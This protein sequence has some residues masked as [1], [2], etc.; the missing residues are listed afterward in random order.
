MKQVNRKFLEEQVKNTLKEIGDSRAANLAGTEEFEKEYGPSF[1]KILLDIIVGLP[2][3]SAESYVDFAR[4]LEETG[5]Y[6]IGAQKY[7]KKIADTMVNLNNPDSRAPWN[8]LM[9]RFAQNA[10]MGADESG[11][12]LKSFNLMFKED[13]AKALVKVRDTGIKR[14]QSIP[15]DKKSV[16]M[17]ERVLVKTVED[18]EDVADEFDFNSG[19][20]DFVEFNAPWSKSQSIPMPKMFKD[21]DALEES[22]IYKDYAKDM[23]EAGNIKEE[24]EEFLMFHFIGLEQTNFQK[25]YNRLMLKSDLPD[26]ASAVAAY[27]EWNQQ[28]VKALAGFADITFS[29][30]TTAA[31]L[32]S[33]LTG[34]GAPAGAALA[35]GGTA[36]KKAV[37]SS[38]TKSLSSAPNKVA[39]MA[40]RTLESKKLGK[41]IDFLDGTLA[42]LS[43]LVTSTVIQKFENILD[44]W[45]GD[46]KELNNYFKSN[47]K[48]KKPEERIAFYEEKIY[49]AISS[50]AKAQAEI[51][52][53]VG[54][55]K[56][57]ISTRVVDPKYMKSLYA[58]FNI[59]KIEE[60]QERAE[61]ITLGLSNNLDQMSKMMNDIKKESG[62]LKQSVEGLLKADKVAEQEAAKKIKMPL[63]KA[64]LTNP[65]T[66][67]PKPDGKKS[68]SS[69][70]LFFVG[71]SIAQGMRDSSGGSDGETHTGETSQDILDKIRARFQTKQ[72]QEQQNNKTAIISVGT[73]DAM[74]AAAGESNFTPEK[75]SE[76]IKQIV[77]TLK[78]NGY[79]T[80]K[81]MPLMHHGVK[82]RTYTM[83]KGK[84]IPFNQEAHK[85]F[86]NSVNSQLSASKL[87][88]FDNSVELYND[89][90]HPKSPKQLL[91]KALSGSTVA[92]ALSVRSKP[93][94]PFDPKQVDA[95][96]KTSDK[97]KQQFEGDTQK[98]NAFFNKPVAEMSNVPR[99]QRE[100]AVRKYFEI[101][102]ASS[103]TGLPLEVLVKQMGAESGYINKDFLGDTK[104]KYGPSYGIGQILRTTGETLTKKSG[105][106][107]V[108]Y[109][110]I[111]SNNLDTATSE[112]ILNTKYLSRNPWWENATETQKQLLILYAYNMGAGNSKRGVKGFI[113]RAGGDIERGLSDMNA[114][115]VKKYNYKMGYGHK[116]MAAAG[117]SVPTVDFDNVAIKPPSKTEKPKSTSDSNATVSNKE[118]VEA[119]ISAISAA[120]DFDSFRKEFYSLFNMDSTSAEMAYNDIIAAKNFL[121]KQDLSKF[122]ER[123]INYLKSQHKI[124]SSSWKEQYKKALK[125]GDPNA[126]KLMAFFHRPI[127]FVS[128]FSRGLDKILG[129]KNISFGFEPNN[130][131]VSTN[132]DGRTVFY[133]QD[134][135]GNQKFNE[136]LSNLEMLKKATQAVLEKVSS[137]Y[138][139][140]PDK[141]EQIRF[142]ERYV[143]VLDEIANSVLKTLKDP[144]ESAIR[145]AH[146][147]A[148]LDL[149]ARTAK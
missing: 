42:Q 77:N 7:Y 105:Q 8:Q 122:S 147:V 33:A 76:N 142:I 106:D 6:G 59:K 52:N 10:P 71:D 40:K 36:A 22:G 95:Y 140:D 141:K 84:K 20:L 39:A 43:G 127:F 90:V 56:D 100:A 29:T 102:G 35:A 32:L 93:V 117:Q 4:W 130:K 134:Y 57:F 68:V 109:L 132:Q 111:A 88:L 131:R 81:V 135:Q 69:S 148:G 60:Y 14:I 5:T 89:G 124:Y 98:I 9:M 54:F 129:S 3:G 74:R 27:N 61:K 64:L 139:S 96:N 17:I 41:T 66:S 30:A 113:T 16:D 75:T 87:E 50:L 94:S 149:A 53:S 49:P 83:Y 18:L 144:S 123:M 78:Q 133:K 72:I 37:L 115:Y 107:L 108:D 55:E 121:F 136:F 125:A 114:H 65:E 31:A 13:L 119:L 103:K 63:P 21:I 45:R 67:A 46:L 99:S 73:N 85:K 138:K 11:V 120:E 12:F 19:V 62:G 28:G 34:V 86:V 48:D 92:P 101:S 137:L 58:N 143:N 51:Y 23:I 38:L 116:I 80:V 82:N 97:Q 26:V 70:S 118:S 24:M 47:F 145:K 15:D 2:F 146:S 128:I 79:T 91:N 112:H 104:S 1:G 25:A 110:N 126:E 44:W